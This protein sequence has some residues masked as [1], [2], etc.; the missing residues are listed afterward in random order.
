VSKNDGGPAYPVR[1]PNEAGMTLLD[2]FA[3]QALAGLLAADFEDQFSYEGV[4]R[5]AYSIAY[6]ML[7]AREGR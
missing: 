3:G 6:E 2:Y 4:A 5:A 7:N 1:W